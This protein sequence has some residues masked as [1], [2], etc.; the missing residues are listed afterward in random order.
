MKAVDTHCHLQFEAYDED[1]D[2]VSHRT[3]DELEFVINVGTSLDASKKG[4]KLAA[5]YS[6]FY[7]SVAI[8]PHHVDQWSAGSYDDLKTLAKDQ[9]VVA[10]GE[11]GLDKHLYKGYPHP[12]LKQQA[13]MLE[14]H[15]ELALDLDLPLLFHCRLAYD[16]LFNQIKPHA[17]KIRGLMHCF[18]GDKKQAEK[19]L[20]L[21]LYLSFSGNSTYRNNDYI[22]QVIKFAPAER[23]LAE[24][25]SPFLPP[26]PYRGRR[27]EPAY[28]KIV[29]AS[30][31]KI[32]GWSE[33]KA[34]QITTDNAKTLLKIS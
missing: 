7:A 32:K 10:V 26:E 28:V 19:L 4:L 22:R 31:A 9:K 23:I 5:K 18:M 21:G 6:N 17:G 14:R 20:D 25:D 1:R 29:V 8:H 16:E 3:S 24:T 33:E 34:S 12:D 2:L 11:T 15:L 13:Q 30:I 27:N